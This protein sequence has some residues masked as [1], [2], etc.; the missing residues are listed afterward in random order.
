MTSSVRPRV[1]G[2][3]RPVGA[4]SAE[5][6]ARILR[7]ACEIINERGYEAATFQ[8][9]AHRAGLSRPTMHYYFHTREQMY[10]C[11][12]IE[13]F[14]LIAD[15]IEQASREDTLLRQ[16][17][18]FL[19]ASRHLEFADRS[20]MRFIITCRLDVHRNPGLLTSASAAVSAV[21]RF[22]ESIV[23]GAIKRHEI[24][25]DTDPAAVAN[26]LLAVFWGMG[27]YAGFLDNSNNVKGVAKQLYGLFVH[28]LLDL[29][30]SEHSLLID[31]NAPVSDAV[32]GFAGIWPGLTL[33]IDVPAGQQFIAANAAQTVQVR[34][35]FTRERVRSLLYRAYGVESLVEGIGR[36]DTLDAAAV[37]AVE[38]DVI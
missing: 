16:L 18:T 12:V 25:D 36:Y 13:A 20:L 29:P 35:D 17:S 21:R 8:A 1:A 31:P 37:P 30:K 27:F 19:T 32:D 3:G 11:L 4:D 22:Y 33:V 15:S 14:S 7:A 2:R 38:L 6:R 34:G 5:T 24:L 26:M 28:G 10:E 9:I 23:D